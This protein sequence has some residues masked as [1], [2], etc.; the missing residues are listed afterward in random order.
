[1]PHL[2]VA[3]F[4]NKLRLSLTHLLV[5]LF[6]STHMLNPYVPSFVDADSIEMT[7]ELTGRERYS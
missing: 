1:M 5:H 7:T 2:H 3:D 6:I 4:W